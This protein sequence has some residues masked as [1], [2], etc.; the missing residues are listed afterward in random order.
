MIGD[1]DEIRDLILAFETECEAGDYTDTGAAWDLL[2]HIKRICE[3][4]QEDYQE[5]EPSQEYDDDML[6]GGEEEP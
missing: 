5:Q 2:L 1:L 4:R 6:T 3:G